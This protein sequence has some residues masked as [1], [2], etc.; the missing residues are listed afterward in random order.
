MHIALHAKTSATQNVLTSSHCVPYYSITLYYT[1]G[2]SLHK[3][4]TTT[5]HQHMN[6]NKEVHRYPHH[7]FQYLINTAWDLPTWNSVDAVTACSLTHPKAA[8]TTSYVQ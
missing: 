5:S 1:E 6:W 8:A 3:N 2:P 7:N 4:T